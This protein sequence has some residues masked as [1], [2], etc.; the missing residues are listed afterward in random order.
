MAYLG[1]ALFAEGP[2]DHR[3]LKPL[4]RRLCEN[5]CLNHAK[6][7]LPCARMLKLMKRIK[8][9]A[10]SRSAAARLQTDSVRSN[11]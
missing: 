11:R 7:I 10:S 8:N 4:L 6:T 3:F 2:T 1:L 5:V 9:R